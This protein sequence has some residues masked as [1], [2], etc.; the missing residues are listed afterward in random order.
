[1]RPSNCHKV[2]EDVSSWKNSSECISNPIYLVGRVAWKQGQDDSN[3]ELL[4]CQGSEV[5]AMG[6]GDG[7]KLR[8]EKSKKPVTGML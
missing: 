2:M 4:S 1:M 7:G 5:V 8:A 6:V 3:L